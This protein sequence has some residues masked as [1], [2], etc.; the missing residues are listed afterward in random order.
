MVCW[1]ISGPPVGGQGL[2]QHPVHRH[3]GLRGAGDRIHSQGP[4][5]VGRKRQ[6]PPELAG[7]FLFGDAPA[8][9][10]RLLLFQDVRL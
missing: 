2:V 8:E 1:K 6:A 4:L 10:G 5:R 9:P 7:E 3:R